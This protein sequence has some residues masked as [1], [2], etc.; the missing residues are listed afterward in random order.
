MVK[1]CVIVTN[2]EK[3]FVNFAFDIIN[4]HKQM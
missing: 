2:I 4:F 3:G 1:F